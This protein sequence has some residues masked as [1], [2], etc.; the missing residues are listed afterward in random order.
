MFQWALVCCAVITVAS[1]PPQTGD[2]VVPGVVSLPVLHSDPQ[3]DS[4]ILSPGTRC[5]CAK[6]CGKCGGTSC[7]DHPGGGSN[8]CCGDIAKSN[9]T[10]DKTDPPCLLPADPP[11]PPGPPPPLRPKRG[12]VADSHSC[13]DPLLLNTS[14]WYYGYNLHNPYRKPGLPGNCSKANATGHL[15]ERF[16]PMEWCFTSQPDVPSYVNR[17]FFMGYNE[18]NNLHNCNKEPQDVAAHWGDIMKQF[19]DSM[20][21]SPAT[22]GDGIPWFDAFFGNCTAMYGKAGCRLSYLAAHCYSCSPKETLTYLETLYKRY[23]LKVWLTEFSCG[24]GA[25]A[26]SMDDH[27]YYM[28]QVVPLLDA[29]PFVYRYAWMS[30]HDGS[31]RRGL[32][33]TESVGGVNR[34]ALTPV[35]KLYNSL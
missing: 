5:C 28:K 7:Q 30:A 19:P 24:D 22:S 9:R 11:S 8:C 3:C 26:R 15:D 14:G 1:S 6:E 18:P 33:T 13:D 27:L 4:G 35:G 2:A 29:A 23:G 17:T 31:G 25:Q 20:L 32:V 10:C 12:F 21:V 34:S 16:A